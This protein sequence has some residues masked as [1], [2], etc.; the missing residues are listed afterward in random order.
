MQKIA[1]DVATVQRQWGWYL[2]LGIVM[3]LVG[4]YAL[5]AETLA[6]L[7]SV[8]ALGFVLV[9]AGIAQ[10]VAAFM[11]RGAGH[12]ILMLLVGFLDIIVGWALLQHPTIGAL[13]ITLL[14][15]ALLIFGGI[16]RFVSALW[17]QVPNYGWVA[18][19]GVISFILGALLWM[20]W[21]VS[22]F[23]FIGFAVG[24]NFIFSGIAWTSLGL[25]LKSA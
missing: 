8:F 14:L 19:S 13:A 16:F 4:I 9:I 1:S 15:A 10:I 23:W 5:Y 2:A 12:V 21:P 7:A 24:L 25:R 11:A 17:L 6:T 20:Q 18:A 3:I 22:A